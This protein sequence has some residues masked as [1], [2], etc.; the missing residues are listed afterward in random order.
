M[1]WRSAE[2][3]ETVYFCGFDL[4][5][6]TDVPSALGRYH[7]PVPHVAQAVNLSPAGT[8]KGSSGLPAVEA[9]R[10]ADPEAA[11]PHRGP[12]LQRCTQRTIRS[13]GLATGLHHHL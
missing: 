5:V 8:N 10:G 4:H 3:E 13:A 1:G 2:F 7:L 6:V 12:R 11:P 9:A